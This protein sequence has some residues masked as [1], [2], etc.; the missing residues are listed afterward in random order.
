[1]QARQ[2]ADK[3]TPEGS[4]VSLPPISPREQGGK[5][6]KQD[7]TSNTTPVTNL[8]S[9]A[10]SPITK[11]QGTGGRSEPPDGHERQF[12]KVVKRCPL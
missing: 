7:T 8:P 9:I 5:Q 6:G 1:M 4:R 12:I 11:S 2:K 10:H 3:I